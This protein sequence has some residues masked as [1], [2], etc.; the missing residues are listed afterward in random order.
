[1][2]WRWLL[3]RMFLVLRHIHWALRLDVFGDELSDIEDRLQARWVMFCPWGNPRALLME[4][5]EAMQ[6]IMLDHAEVRSPTEAEYERF[7]DAFY[8]VASANGDY[9]LRW[10]L[11]REQQERQEGLDLA[12]RRAA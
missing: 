2:W 4:L 11:T 6:P 1:M 8:K 5:Y 3:F 10:Q 9:C 12:H 7:Y